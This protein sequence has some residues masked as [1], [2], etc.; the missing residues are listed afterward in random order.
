M[1]DFRA[2]RGL[3]LLVSS[4]VRRH[5]QDVIEYLIEENRVL[6]E[7]SRGR[8]VVLTDDQRRR[9]AAKGKVVGRP[10]LQ[11]V[12]TIVK[13]DTI[14]AWHRKLIERSCLAPERRPG[15]PRVPTEIRGL[16][17]RMAM[18]NSGYVKL[19]IM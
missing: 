9:L 5:Q 11:Q 16:A 13:A 18:E 2:I 19:V 3:L 7:Q 8:R 14:L 1:I 6:L 12:A 4:W 10:D 17:I 15:R